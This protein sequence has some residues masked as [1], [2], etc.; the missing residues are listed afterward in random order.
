MNWL[1][2]EPYGGWQEPH[3]SKSN[4]ASKYSL[5]SGHSLLDLRISHQGPSLKVPD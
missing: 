4:D 1:L 5:S 2:E 3:A